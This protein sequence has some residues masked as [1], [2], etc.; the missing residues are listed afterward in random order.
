VKWNK[1]GKMKKMITNT[2]L[3]RGL[4]GQFETYM[5][6]VNHLQYKER[7][8]YSHL[9]NLFRTLAKAEGHQT[10]FIWEKLQ[11]KY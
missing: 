3:C 9:R 2:E 4:P 8:N 5:N 6:Y 10:K 1:I 7:P 11:L